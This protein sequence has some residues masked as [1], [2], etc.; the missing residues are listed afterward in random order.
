[1]NHISSEKH[2]LILV[3]IFIGA[4]TLSLCPDFLM[5]VQLSC[6]SKKVFGLNC[7][8]CGMTR[9]FILMIGGFPPRHNMFSPVFALLI[10]FIYPFGIG[11]HVIKRRESN[12]P[13][14]RIRNIFVV[15]MATMFII[16]NIR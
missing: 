14:A 12:M 9:D 4:L 15:A 5:N 7:P 2:L 11:V 10:F 8:F 13:Y 1:M 16:N 6:L 3:I